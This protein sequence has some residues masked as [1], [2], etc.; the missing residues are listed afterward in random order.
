MGSDSPVVTLSNP[1]QFPTLSPLLIPNATLPP[2]N[3]ETMDPSLAPTFVPTESTQFPSGSPVVTLSPSNVPSNSPIVTVS[4]SNAPTFAPTRSPTG[5]P[6][7]HVAT[8]VPS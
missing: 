1:T 2:S 3:V 4:P 7:T 6:S 5:A 8:E